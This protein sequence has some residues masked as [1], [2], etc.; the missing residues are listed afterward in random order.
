[1]RT[2]KIT[3]SLILLFF[4]FI[5]CSSDSQREEQLMDNQQNQQLDGQM[6]EQIMQDPNARQMMMNHMTENPERRR[7]MMNHFRGEMQQMNQEA[8]ADRMQSMMEDP[9][10]RQQMISHLQQMQSML[11]SEEFDREEMQRLMQDSDM[12]R[13]HM[14]CMQL[15][16]DPE[17]SMN[18][19]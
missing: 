4:L 1:M 13:M 3:I 15:M 7:E 18:Q 14:N 6:M 19:D 12:M 11:E 16:Q 2:L 8:M 9:E 10:H 17:T 5:R